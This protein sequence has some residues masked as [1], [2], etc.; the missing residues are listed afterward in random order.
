MIFSHVLIDYDKEIT[1]NDTNFNTVINIM[2][3][4]L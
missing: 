4:C 1:D 3:N 2:S